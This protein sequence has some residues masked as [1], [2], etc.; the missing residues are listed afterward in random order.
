MT[1]TAR[2]GSSPRAWGTRPRPNESYRIARF[3]PTGVGNTGQ[4]HSRPMEQPVHPHGRGEHGKY[5]Y[6]VHRITGS[7]PRA[8]G[9]RP[10]HSTAAL[11]SRFIPTGVGNTGAARNRCRCSPVHPHGRGEHTSHFTPA[12]SRYGSSPRAW[13]THRPARRPDLPWRF[14]PTGVGN[15]RRTLA[16]SRPWPVHPHGR[17]EHLQRGLR[18]VVDAGSS[19]RAWGTRVS[20]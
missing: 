20:P 13:G 10:A 5:P 7:S 1:K 14:I 4:A 15:T 18:H 12:S 3:I 17:G 19:P 16:G 9:T 6:A 11:R 8:W 2:H